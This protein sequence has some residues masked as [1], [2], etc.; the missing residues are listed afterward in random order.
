M[1][2]SWEVDHPKLKVGTKEDSDSD[3]DDDEDS[4][5]EKKYK[6]IR[7]VKYDRSL[8]AVADN[9]AD[10][11]NK[12]ILDDC[13]KIFKG[14][15]ADNVYSDVEKATMKYIREHYRFEKTADQWIRKA[16]SSF[17]RQRGK[18]QKGEGDDNDGE[19]LVCSCN[20]P[21]SSSMIDCDAKL[22]GCYESYHT[23]CVGLEN[24]SKLPEIWFCPMCRKKKKVKRKKDA[25]IKRKNFKMIDEKKYDAGMISAANESQ[26]N[27]DHKV[28]LV[29]AKIIFREAIDGNKI[30]EVEYDTIG[31][32]K[33]HYKWDD[34]A[35][36]WFENAVTSWEIDHPRKMKSSSSKDESDESDVET[37]D[38]EDGDGEREGE[39]DPSDTSKDKSMEVDDKSKPPIQSST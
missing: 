2:Y 30:T 12:L 23:K 5:E 25:T 4:K 1:Q 31:Y 16:I 11:R 17:T 32:V 9:A 7:G 28:S 10:E 34:A 6:K 29:N 36:T 13:K 39:P 3:S 19:E 14:I 38:P 37:S 24:V 21:H 20:K 8:L 18:K 33:Q 15:T 22:P 26:Q 27:K 35:K